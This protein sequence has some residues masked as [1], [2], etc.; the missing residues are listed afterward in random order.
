MKLSEIFI[1]TRLLE[2]AEALFERKNAD[3]GQNNNIV[4]SWANQLGMTYDELHLVW[5]KAKQDVGSETDFKKIVGAFKRKVTS[6]KGVTKK[7]LMADGKAKFDYTV[8]TQQ[9]MD[10]LLDDKPAP[11]SA[12][13][14][15]V[16]KVKSKMSKINAQMRE[17]KAKPNSTKTQKEKN[18]KALAEL[19]KK[20]AELKASIA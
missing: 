14:G 7:K 20:K 10:Q 4:K 16:K 2:L 18:K 19:R 11:K 5:D 6:L 3:D 1:E 12:K 9:T 8:R 13:P 17:I 15:E